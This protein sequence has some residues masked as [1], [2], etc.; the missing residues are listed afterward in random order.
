MLAG[1]CRHRMNRIRATELVRSIRDSGLVGLISGDFISDSGQ[2][3]HPCLR[4]QLFKRSS[5][6]RY[7]SLRDMVAPFVGYRVNGD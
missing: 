6:L 4:V 5:A 7:L 1:A 2:M 3:K